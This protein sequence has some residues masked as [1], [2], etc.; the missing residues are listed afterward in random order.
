MSSHV[1]DDTY[2]PAHTQ[3][4]DELAA[5]LEAAWGCNLHRFPHFSPVDWYGERFNALCAVLEAKVRTAASD[6][7]PTVYF[8]LR[9]QTSLQLVGGGFGVPALFVV[10]FT[11]GIRWINANDAGGYPVRIA[12]R[13]DRGRPHDLEPLIE[14]PIDAMTKLKE[15]E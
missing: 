14:V 6:T 8:A 4:E 5:L 11:D 12:G 1:Y 2:T 13:R 10:R 15:A 9:K 7:Y 3:E